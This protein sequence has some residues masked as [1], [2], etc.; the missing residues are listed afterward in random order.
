MARGSRPD[1]ACAMEV[2][3]SGAMPG[4]HCGAR[5]RTAAIV[6]VVTTPPDR[7]R[8][9]RQMPQRPDIPR[10]GSGSGVAVAPSLAETY[11]DKSCRLSLWKPGRQHPRQCIAESQRLFD[12]HWAARVL[13]IRAPHGVVAVVLK[14]D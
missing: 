11:S 7:T 12:A 2:M 8:P 1:S 14:V 3:V 6:S 4:A 5:A 10:V 13:P 9:A